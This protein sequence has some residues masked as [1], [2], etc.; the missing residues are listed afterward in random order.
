[1]QRRKQ[2]LRDKLLSLTLL[3]ASAAGLFIC[4]SHVVPYV[5]EERQEAALQAELAALH[6]GTAEASDRLPAAQSSAPGHPL[7]HMDPEVDLVVGLPN[8]EGITDA[9]VPAELPENAT[10]EA[11]NVEE[12]P[13][14]DLDP[15]NSGQTESRENS[16][17]VQSST[18]R[19]SG[20]AALH[21]K[22]PDCIAWISID[23]TVIDY[24][25][26][27]HPQSKNYYIHRDFYGRR[28]SSGCLYVSEICNPDTCDNLII[29]GHHMSRGT[30]FAALD[31]Y[32]KRAFYEAHPTIRLERLSGVETYEII[33]VLTTPVYTKN[34]FKYYAFA[35]AENEEAFNTYISSCQARALYDIGKTAAFGDKLLTLSTCEYSQKNGRMVVVARRLDP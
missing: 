14:P 10:D 9:E 33:F 28:S 16:T 34:D 20:L 17:R 12:Q 24:P 3:G 35:Q 22:N 18:V 8:E 11:V 23:G 26:M 30:M 27:Y 4:L 5:R 19:H 32:K 13:A 31:K 7:A 6:Y 21:Q 29:Y 15:P 25:V 2:K 1:M